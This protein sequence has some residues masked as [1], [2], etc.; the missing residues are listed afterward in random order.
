MNGRLLFFLWMLLSS[1]CVVMAES[2]DEKRELSKLKKTIRGLSAIDTNYIEPQHYNYTVMLQTTYN[3][4]LYQIRSSTG[5]EVTFS[6]DVVMKVGPYIGW[7]WFFLGY[8]FDLK[9]ISFGGN[10]QKRELDFSIYGSKVG[11]DLFYR[12]TGSDYKIRRANMGENV[13]I[14]KL[15]GLP[16]DGISVGIT[17]INLYYIFNYRRFS[18]PAAFSQS[19]C[20]KL[21]CGSWIAGIGYT[22]NSLELDYGKLK[23]LVSENCVPNK[24][25]LDSG[26]MFN[27]IKYY[28]INLSCGYAYN[29]V[30]AKNCLMCASGALA[31]AYKHSDGDTEDDN[32]HGFKFDNVNFDGIGRFGLVYN[33]T[34]WY[35]GLSAILHAYTYR[36]SRFMTNNVFGSLNIY[37]GYN[38]G[39]KERYKK[40]QNKR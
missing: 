34:R 21:S 4:D 9:N 15:N 24:V 1:F 40:K 12:R 29:W 35:A 20:Q 26:L 38:F 36:K 2:D 28:D 25:E 16:F 22:R 39:K 7:R 31:V 5:Q 13:D 30:F 10:K 8:T 23:S 14:S 6:P 3:Y 19:T 17:G 37:I 11:I 18:Y 27:S 32:E 33:N